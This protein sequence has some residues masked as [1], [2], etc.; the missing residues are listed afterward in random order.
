MKI[1]IKTKPNNNFEQKTIHELVNV[2]RGTCNFDTFDTIE[3]VLLNRDM[4]LRTEKLELQEE[5]QKEVLLRKQAVEKAKQ[6]EEVC[7]K[8]KR[9]KESYETLLKDV[10]IT[11]LPDR[12]MI[13]ELKKKNN[14]L[15]C[16]VRKLK[17]K[18]VDGENKLDDIRRKNVELVEELEN[19]VLELTKLKEILEEDNI[20]LDELRG[21][22]RVLE[23]DR[24]AVVARLKIHIGELEERVMTHLATINEFKEENYKLCIK[25]SKLQERVWKLMEDTELLTNFDA[26]G[27]GNNEWEPHAGPM[28]ADVFG[29]DTVE[30][31]PLRRNEDVRDSLGV[32]ASTQP[33]NI[34]GKDA[35]G[36]SSASRRVKSGKD[37]EIII[38]DD[39]DG[40]R[41]ISQRVRGK[42]TIFGPVVKDVYPSSSMATQQKSKFTNAE[43]DTAK[44][45]FS[46]PDIETPSS[47]D[48]SSDDDNLPIST[49][50]L[51]GKKTKM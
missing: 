28:V 6:L 14:E 8:G 3:G 13:K 39:D 49:A 1:K 20:A 18:C 30:A 25:H 24:N 43:V 15:E 19:K 32:A 38:L 2:L 21:K 26:S 34:G 35:K 17:E 23:S 31:A 9:I 46:F 16:E 29:H 51:R 4:T 11:G 10:K 12:N 33:H 47:S 5:L 22:V 44:R 41:S 45:K 36:A 50:I 37:S 40:N 48:N 27:G 7:E 42:K